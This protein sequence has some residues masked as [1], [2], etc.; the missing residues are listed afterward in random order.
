MIVRDPLLNDHRAQQH[1][2]AIHSLSRGVFCGSL[3]IQALTSHRSHA[4]ENGRTV[5]HL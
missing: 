5:I 4:S 2:R 1:V 3:L